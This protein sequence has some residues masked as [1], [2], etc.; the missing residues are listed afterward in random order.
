MI[1]LVHTLYLCKL[2]NAVSACAVR[3]CMPGDAM[4]KIVEELGLT[5]HVQMNRDPPIRLRGM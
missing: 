1:V 5:F 3:D 4:R 2:D